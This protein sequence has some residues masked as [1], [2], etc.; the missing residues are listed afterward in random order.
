MRQCR[1]AS[2]LY[3]DELKMEDNL[4]TS[5]KYEDN[6]ALFGL[7]QKNK[8]GDKKHW[9]GLLTDSL[10]AYGGMVGGGKKNAQN[11]YKS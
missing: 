1:C 6:L 3:F 11:L 9:P 4:Y 5:L 2:G 8:E 10:W 7:F